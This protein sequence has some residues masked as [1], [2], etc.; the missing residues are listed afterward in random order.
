MGLRETLNE[1]PGA[2][3]AAAGVIILLALVWVVWSMVG[4]GGGLVSSDETLKQ[5]FTTDLG[6]TWFA[7]DASKLPPFQKD[8]KTA[9]RVHVYTCNGGKDKF[10]VYM[11][12]Y[13]PEAKKRIEENRAKGGGDPG[14][15]EGM[16]ISGMEVAKV[17]TDIWVKMG[18]PRAAE[19]RDPV[20]PPGKGKPEDLEPV[21]P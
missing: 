18:D 15:F 17:G 11:E 7:D 3:T 10:A 6:K 9:Y 16:G 19:I 12:R 1:H 5:F 13:T 14:V 21:I 2:T 8:G 4:G 20:C